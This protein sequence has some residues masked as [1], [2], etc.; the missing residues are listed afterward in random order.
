MARAKVRLEIGTL[1]RNS[2]VWLDDVEVTETVASITVEAHAND[3]TR[4]LLVLLPS[5]VVIEG[6][7]DV[8]RGE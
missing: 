8:T 7:A 5:D 3:V 6:E 1:G 2:R 4:V